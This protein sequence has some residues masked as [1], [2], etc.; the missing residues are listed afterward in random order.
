LRLSRRVIFFLSAVF[1]LFAAVVI[2]RGQILWAA[3][4]MLVNTGPPSKADIV[5]VLAGDSSG[6]RVLKGAEL[7]RQGYA[8]KVFISNGRRFYGLNESEAAANFAVR[9]GYSRDTMIC[10]SGTPSSTEG[11]SRQVIPVLRSL[12][13]HTVLLVT[14]PSHTARATRIFRKNAPDLR[15]DPVAAPDPLWCGGYWWTGRECEKTW[16]LEELKTVTGPLGI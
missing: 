12:G 1:L 9:H 11:E 6:N 8:P 14:S 5:L 13:V 3:G 4:A 15:I 16:F 10:F 7:V 2:F